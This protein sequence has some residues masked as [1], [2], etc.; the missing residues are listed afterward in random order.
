VD[1]NLKNEA[2]AT[3][4]VGGVFESAL[5]HISKPHALQLAGRSLLQMRL[6]GLPS[7]PGTTLYPDQL[8]D[9]IASQ[10]AVR[11]LAPLLQDESTTLPCLACPR[12]RFVFIHGHPCRSG[13]NC[14][15]VIP[16]TFSR[17]KAHLVTIIACPK[18]QPR[19]ASA[20]DRREP[21]LAR[22]QESTTSGV[23]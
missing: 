7:N 18:G 4:G 9:C 11:L 3:L 5:L 20:S 21:D 1:S 23:R 16:Q 10:S 8:Q 12:S 14:G 6:A 2:F 13:R 15:I 17:E 19:I 22:P